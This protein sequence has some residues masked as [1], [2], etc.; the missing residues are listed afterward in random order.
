MKMH[1]ALRVNGISY[2]STTHQ[3]DDSSVLAIC[4]DIKKGQVEC[5]QKS[6]SMCTKEL[7]PNFRKS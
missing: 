3:L 7:Q 2:R 5:G 1:Y 6:K 4:E